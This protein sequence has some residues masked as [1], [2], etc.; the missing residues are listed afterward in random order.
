VAASGTYIGIIKHQ[1]P[2]EVVLDTGPG[3]HV[4]LRRAEVSAMEPLNVSTMPPGLEHLLETQELS[5]L[6]AFLQSLPD[7]VDRPSRR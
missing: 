5:D 2:D 7:L 1:G 4:R 6:V 3:T